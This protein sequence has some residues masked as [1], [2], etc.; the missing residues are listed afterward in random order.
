MVDIRPF[1]DTVVGIGY[2]NDTMV[3]IGYSNDTT[4]DI[5]YPKDTMVGVCGEF[6]RV[7]CLVVCFLYKLNPN[8]RK[9]ICC[10]TNWP[11]MPIS[12]YFSWVGLALAWGVRRFHL[13]T[14]MFSDTTE[15]GKS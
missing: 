9:I 3:D 2:A 11:K 12:T 13:N 8:P 5:G 15:S 6:G 1:N 7:G 14:N 10:G 4:V